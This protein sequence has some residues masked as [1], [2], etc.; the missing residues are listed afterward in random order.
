MNKNL[1]LGLWKYLLRIPRSIWQGE[2]ARNAEKGRSRISFMSAD[3]HKIRDFVVLELPR[4]GTPIA[5]ED[6]ARGVELPLQ[7]TREILD[8]L[9]KGMTFLFRNAKGEV[10]WAYPV[11][12]EPTP[13][14]M[15]FSRGE[16]IYA[17]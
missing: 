8:E 1:L 4:R 11:T 3:H 17:A 10:A 16:Q 15:R 7:R 5:P 6:I 9:E 13:H 12:A 14:R 2:V